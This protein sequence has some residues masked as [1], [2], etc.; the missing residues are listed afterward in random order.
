M[1]ILAHD[2]KT[3]AYFGDKIAVEGR[4]CSFHYLGAD[5]DASSIRSVMDQE[6]TFVG[7]NKRKGC[8]NF[9]VQFYEKQD[10]YKIT[11]VFV[12]NDMGDRWAIDVSDKLC[13]EGESC[14]EKQ[15]CAQD[16]HVY[17]C[18]FTQKH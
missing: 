2:E 6:L 5:N 14:F 12:E 3:F 18:E 15:E 8:C 1:Q 9:R 7:K 13:I 4:A 17:D 16:S 11:A 10:S